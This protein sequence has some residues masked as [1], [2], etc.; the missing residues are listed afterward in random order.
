MSRNKWWELNSNI[1]QEI[2]LCQP[3]IQVLTDRLYAFEGCK[4][5]RCGTSQYMNI[6]GKQVI[7]EL[8]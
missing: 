5:H 8:A 6:F 2:L 3:S 1:T 4:S 7:T